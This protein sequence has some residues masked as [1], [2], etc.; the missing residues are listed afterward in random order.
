[1]SKL[2]VDDAAQLV[3]SCAQTP[4]QCT[5]VLHRRTGA[6][7]GFPVRSEFAEQVP[8]EGVQRSDHALDEPPEVDL[9][10]NVFGQVSLTDFVDCQMEPSTF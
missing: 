8:S 5:D 10:N 2:I 3:L 1:M 9:G 6:L 7:S 4:R